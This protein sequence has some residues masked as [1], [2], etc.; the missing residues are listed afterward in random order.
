ME[1]KFLEIRFERNLIESNIYD[2]LR[3]EC[4]HMSYGDTQRLAR[5]FA[6]KLC[7][8]WREQIEKAKEYRDKNEIH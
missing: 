2:E 6:D 3:K 4:P 7:G 1:K 8:E 5:N